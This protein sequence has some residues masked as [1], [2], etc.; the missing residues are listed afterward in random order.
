MFA[1]Y[2]KKIEIKIANLLKDRRRIIHV[3]RGQSPPF[4]IVM[5]SPRW[6]H[7]TTNMIAI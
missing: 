5:Y 7:A 3:H 1:I 4:V 2:K 6:I